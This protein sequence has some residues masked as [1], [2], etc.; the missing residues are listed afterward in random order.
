MIMA[1]SQGEGDV[2]A[3]EMKIRVD[4]DAEEEVIS[5][6]RWWQLR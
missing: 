4:S 2:N 6:Q 1:G 5:N 3:T